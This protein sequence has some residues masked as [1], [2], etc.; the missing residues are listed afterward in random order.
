MLTNL[1]NLPLPLAVWLASDNYL[2]ADSANEISTTTL[3]KSPRYIIA[4]IRSRFP[5]LF[6]KGLSVP[7]EP[8][9]I[10]DKIPARFG[11]AIH[12]AIDYALNHDI[13]VLKKLGVSEIALEKILVNPSPEII[14]PDS[15]CI[16]TEQRIKKQVGNFIISGQF[17][18]VINGEL[19][20]IKTTST[21]SYTSGCNDKK[22]ITQGSIYR[23]LNPELIT[24]DTLTINF[25]FTDWS[26]NYAMSRDGYPKTRALGKTFPLWSLDETERYIKEKISLI[27]KYWDAPL[28]NIPCCS[29]EDLYTSPPTYKYYKNGYSE[30][31]KSTKNFDNIHDASLYQAQQGGKGEIIIDRGKPFTCPLCALSEEPSDDTNLMVNNGWEF[32]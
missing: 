20:D 13:R 28:P 32:V 4:S 18:T 16:Y 9:D 27:E 11:T 31:K 3:M 2:Y 25:V 30:G 22:Y 14:K 5:E 10:V 26:K 1:N 21:Y 24:S 7:L 23:Y 15:I 8:V 12:S 29:E 17:D 19:H 6:P